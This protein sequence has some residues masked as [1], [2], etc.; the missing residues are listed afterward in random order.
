MF[1]NN[2]YVSLQG[3]MHRN[4]YI[5]PSLQTVS[6]ADHRLLKAAELF[7]FLWKSSSKYLVSDSTWSVQLRFGLKPASVS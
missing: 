7:S 4:L 3:V 2:L 6:Y 5:T 1:S